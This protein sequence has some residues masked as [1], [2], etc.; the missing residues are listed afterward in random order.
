MIDGVSITP[1]RRIPDERGMV[2]HML[3][4]DDPH[5]ERFGEVY[6]ATAYPG[7]IKGW[8]LHTRQV[9][10]YAVV[11]GMVKLVIYD[12]R[13]ESPTRGE[14]Q[15]VFLGDDN[16]A[17]VRIPPGVYNGWKCIGTATAMV[18]NCATEPHDPTE[19]RRLDPFSCEVPYSWDLKNG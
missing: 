16:Y 5:F 8:H 17:L 12:P 7:V 15:E 19:M 18:A 10:N 6:F 3:R 14:L 9:Q 2:M 13:D 4:A 1:L 11:A